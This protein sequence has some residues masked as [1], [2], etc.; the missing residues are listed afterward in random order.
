MRK[1]TT[2]LISVCLAIMLCLSGCGNSSSDEIYDSE[3][4]TS[5]E[6]ST[7][8]KDETSEVS[9]TPVSNEGTDEDLVLSEVTIKGSEPKYSLD[10]QQ[11][12]SI[13]MLNYLTFLSTRISS[14]DNSKVLLEETYS[15][16][17]NNTYP[18]A[19]DKRTKEELE[20]LLDILQ[21][22]QMTKTQRER[23]KYL[24][25]QNCAQA[26][27]EAIPN[28]IGL[29]SAVK[30]GNLA[31]AIASVAYMA[32]DSYASYNAYKKAADLEELQANW[33][34]D[35]QEAEILHENRS[36][37]FSYMLDIVHDFNLPGDLT[38]TEKDVDI[39]VSWKNNPNL[40]SRL[41]FFETK[42][43][44]EKYHNFGSYWLELVSD[45][46]LHGDYKK[47]LS[48][49]DS[50]EKNT[51]RIFRKDHEYA[52]TL[53]I[54]IAACNQ[55]LTGNDYIKATNHYVEKLILNSD[56]DDWKLRYIVAQT[57]M[58]MYSKTNNNTYLENAYIIVKN[59]VN[60]LVSSQLD[61]N[62][63]YIAPV[64][65][66]NIPKD[67]TKEKEEEID[68][69]NKKIE[70]ARLKELPPICEPLYMNCQLLFSLAEVLNISEDE[71]KSVDAIL[72][73]ANEELFL[74][75]GINDMF[76]FYSSP[77]NTKPTVKVSMTK[78]SITIPVR[79]LSEDFKIITIMKNDDTEKTFEEWKVKEVIRKDE[80]DINSFAAVFKCK[81]AEEFNYTSGT[82]ITI[83]V[84]PDKA[85]NMNIRKFN[86]VTETEQGFPDLWN[87]Y[88]TFKKVK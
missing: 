24:Y 6:Y 38:L 53:P 49:M 45:Y 20:N 9:T 79:Y 42:E 22:F 54:A 88:Y 86:F 77:N 23:T 28:P 80:K 35:D 64:E 50:F 44:E 58:D 3:I 59:N 56:Q 14:S 60:N 87:T 81:D 26:L 29:L 76:L 31:S 13:Y 17:I 78:D 16:L 51:T 61:Q 69:K 74:T 67:A 25:E 82:T 39:F 18:N 11:L 84:Y 2:K 83:E 63:K 73:N 10:E 75:K 7:L 1:I 8:D 40:E 21:Q 43:S 5:A 27:K 36:S 32:V 52:S 15:S 85:S 37:A 55:I 72:H 34:L 48:A 71:K 19:V 12:N 30:S 66:L 33:E 65:L 46:Y 41:Q 70:K 62:K 68:A 47:C 57:Y 4:N